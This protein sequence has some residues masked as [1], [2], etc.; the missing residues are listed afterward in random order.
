MTSPDARPALTG[1]AGGC[2]FPTA[3]KTLNEYL[4][5]PEDFSLSSVP[6]LRALLG[7][8]CFIIILILAI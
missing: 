7:L 8:A 4:L 3:M 2:R 1:R 5:G 6:A